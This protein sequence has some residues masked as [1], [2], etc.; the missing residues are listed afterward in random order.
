MAAFCGVIGVACVFAAG[1]GEKRTRLF[2]VGAGLAVLLALGSYT[3]LFDL[4]YAVVPGFDMFRGNSKFIF[5]AAIFVTALAAMGLD[6]LGRM[7]SLPMETRGPG[8]GWRNGVCLFCA[9]RMGRFWQ[10]GRVSNVDLGNKAGIASIS[11]SVLRNRARGS[12]TECRYLESVHRRSRICDDSCFG[13]SAAAVFPGL[14]ICWLDLGSLRC[15]FSHRSF[16]NLLRFPIGGRVTRS[17]FEKRLPA[18][19]AWLI[20]RRPTV[21]YFRSCR[22]CGAMILGYYGATLSLSRCRRE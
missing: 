4:M 22:I 5:F 20:V 6:R 8:H 11:R 7:P 19:F 14:F 16:A 10:L 21:V 13:F 12:R 3:P 2:L 1:W 18:I 15:F 9:C 17:I